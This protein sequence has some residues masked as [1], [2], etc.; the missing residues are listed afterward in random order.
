M[1]RIGRGERKTRRP[2]GEDKVTDSPSRSLFG[3]QPTL[4]LWPPLHACSFSQVP[5]AS[6]LEPLERS[7]DSRLAFLTS[8]LHPATG[9]NFLNNIAGHLFSA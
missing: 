4:A 1:K 5:A 3:D 9:M 2:D 8:Y 6:Y 7:L